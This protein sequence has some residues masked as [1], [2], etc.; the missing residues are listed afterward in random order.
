MIKKVI[1]KALPILLA[2][3]LAGCGGGGSGGNGGNKP[4]P[5]PPAPPI[6]ESQMFEAASEAF[7]FGF[8]LVEMMD[9][10]DRFPQLNQLA[11]RA[12]LADANSNNVIRPNNDTLYTSACV[13]LGADWVQ[14]SLPPSPDRYQ[15][16]QV[17]NA[18]TETAAA[19]GP[20]E[21]PV[22]GSDFILQYNNIGTSPLPPGIPVV[23]VSTPF[24]YVLFRTLVDGP[25]DLMAADDAQR[26]I[27]LQSN[28]SAVLD[29]SSPS[30]SS[31]VEDFYLKLMRR[32]HQ[33]PPALLEENLVDSFA[34]AGIVASE[35]PSIES[36]TPAQLSA[37]ENAYQQG[38]QQLNTTPIG[39]TVGSWRFSNPNIANPGN[40][41][42]LRAI[43]ARHAIFPQPIDEAIYART[44]SNGNLNME[45]HLPS[46]W[47]P[48]NDRGFWSLTM[49]NENGFLVD[50]ELNRFSIGDRTPNLVFEPDNSLSLYIQ[51][52]DP[53]GE[54]SANWLPSP[55]GPYTIT[56]RIYL[57]NEETRSP[58]FMLPPLM[59][60]GTGPSPM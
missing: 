53:G 7:T 44:Q 52:Q 17:F 5:E 58:S 9:V 21:I 1:R 26:L 3:L 14:I 34:S 35:N 24:A 47:Q 39:R 51:C 45:L 20:N 48:V 49:Y 15:S 10:C 29:R 54:Q 60:L 22:S 57:P 6:S 28:S 11:Y 4:M 50:N 16:M 33:N 12:T 46:N 23:E 59:G 2:S 37:W 13:Y 40:D 18:Y 30:S 41:Y 56:M 32:L 55:C 42:L 27:A 19:F 31:P 25:D 43:V 8:P 36:I 38:L